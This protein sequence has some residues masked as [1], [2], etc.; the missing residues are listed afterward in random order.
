MTKT[1]TWLELVSEPKC[2]SLRYSGGGN[3]IISIKPHCTSS[4]RS[5]HTKSG[6]HN[7]HSV[8]RAAGPREGRHCV[9]AFCCSL[10]LEYNLAPLHDSLLRILGVWLIIRTSSSS[11]SSSLLPPLPPVGYSPL[12]S[13]RKRSRRPHGLPESKQMKPDYLKPQ[14]ANRDSLTIHIGK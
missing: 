10:K 9:R 7:L 6:H 8:P 5:N 11:T 3:K 13:G 2:I 4:T 14:Q 12:A 1:K